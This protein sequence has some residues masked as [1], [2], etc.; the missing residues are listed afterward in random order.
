MKKRPL[1]IKRFVAAL[2]AAIML[3]SLSISGFAAGSTNASVIT[4]ADIEACIER[5]YGFL[6]HHF[7]DNPERYGIDPASPSELSLLSP[8]AF[9]ET[10]E[11]NHAQVVYLPIVD[12]TN[13]VMAI[14]TV[15]KEKGRISA[16]L[17]TDFAP[18]LNQSVDENESELLLLQD[19]D[20]L[21]AVSADGDVFSLHGENTVPDS[22]YRSF[23]EGDCVLSPD[24]DSDYAVL[25]LDEINDA[26][27]ALAEDSLQQQEVQERKSNVLR[28]GPVVTGENDL[29]NYRPYDIVDQNVNGQQ[30]GLCWAA[31][32]ASMCRFEKPNTWGSLTAQNVADYME[33]GYDD[34]G[35]NNEAKAALQHYLGSPYVPTIM[36]VLSQ[37]DIATVIDNIDPAYLQC[38]RPNGFLRYEYHAVALTG[39]LFADTQIAVQIMDPAYECFKLAT[40]NGS[41]WTFPFGTYTYT[42]I[43]T[44]RL[45]YAV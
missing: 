19:G 36:N 42:W 10:G 29:S 12:G 26:L 44:I 14:F 13:R 34:G 31:V 45:L 20:D 17:G 35:T 25:R 37:A 39:Y 6:M 9:S 16:A 41:N 32:V 18:L 11:G 24:T 8:V 33:I 27:T 43:K 21:L 30:H 28:S 5:D 7:L 22:A 23:V 4:M 3:F 1:V 2:L 40:Y 38:R 15:M